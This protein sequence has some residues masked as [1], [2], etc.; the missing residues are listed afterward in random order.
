MYPTD[1]VYKKG[2]FDMTEV[3]LADKGDTVQVKV[4]FATKIED[5]WRSK[6]WGGNGFSLQMVFIYIDKDG[7]AGSG[8]TGALPGLNVDFNPTAAWEKVL[9]VSPQGT[10]RLKNEIRGKARKQRKDIVLPS[11]VKARGRTLVA[12]FAKA[13]IGGLDR[14]W[15]YQALV[16]SNEGFPKAHDLL[17]RPVN[18][19]KGKHRFGGGSDFDCDPHVIDMLAG[20]ATGGSDEK[21]AQHKALSGYK[22]TDDPDAGKRTQIPMVYPKR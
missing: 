18:E 3:K 22:C 11:R 8:H 21:S 15:G 6:D 10:T 20:S 4:S 16:Q 1:P 14:G 2:S 7:K 19:Y 9:I 12:T 13:D 17:T 5:P